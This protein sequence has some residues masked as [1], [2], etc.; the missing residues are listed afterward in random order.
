MRVPSHMSHAFSMVPSAD[1]QRSK[2][3]RSKGYKTTMNA[4]D[5]VPFYVAEVLPADTVSLRTTA[6][7]RLAT[8]IFPFMD[9]MYADTFF[10]FVPNR[11]V[12]S[13]WEQFNGQ[14]ANPGDSTSYVTP[15]LVCPGA[16]SPG[17]LS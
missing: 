9:N 4:G 3:N 14:Q 1:I 11:L 7:A 12:W 8:P 16:G 5:L 2:F 10:F 15:Q 6:F 17:L 13:H